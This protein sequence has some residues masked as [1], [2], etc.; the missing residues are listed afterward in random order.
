[1][2]NIFQ[3]INRGFTLVETLVALS[4]FS[5]AVLGMLVILGGG[6]KNVNYA[7][8]KIVAT[9]LAQEGIEYFRNLRD[10]YVLYTIPSSDGWVNFTG[11]ILPC[12]GADGC[13]FDDSIPPFDTNSVFQ[14]PDNNGRYCQLYISSDKKYNSALVGDNS[15]FYREIKIV[16]P[17]AGG[18]RIQV[19]STVTWRQGSGTHFVSFSEDLFN[20]Y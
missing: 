16:N 4:I 9:Y 8:S 2:K 20:W 11:G 10:N 5:F 13:G 18:D 14:C 15:G 7:K 12:T 6:V 1:M 19:T 17:G 3:K